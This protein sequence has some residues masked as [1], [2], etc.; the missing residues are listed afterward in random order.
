MDDQIVLDAPGQPVMEERKRKASIDLAPSSPRPRL[1]KS[2]D[3]SSADTD[4]DAQTC[5]TATPPLAPRVPRD[6]NAWHNTQAGMAH[7]AG[8]RRF[9]AFID[10]L[11]GERGDDSSATGTSDSNS[12]AAAASTAQTTPEAATPATPPATKYAD[13]FSDS[14]C[15][16]PDAANWSEAE[17]SA[18]DEDDGEDTTFW[19][20]EISRLQTRLQAA[21][22]ETRTLEEQNAEL[23]ARA[24]QAERRTE[25]AE[26]KA[27]ELGRRCDELR[28]EIYDQKTK[29]EALA[30]EFGEER[31]ARAS[32]VQFAPTTHVRLFN[33][34]EETWRWRKRMEGA[35]RADPLHTKDG[36]T[37]PAL[38]SLAT[39]Y[40]SRPAVAP[41]HHRKPLQG[42]LH[43]P[44]PS[45]NNLRRPHI[46][47]TEMEYL[48]FFKRR[49]VM[50]D[51][52]EHKRKAPR[53]RYWQSDLTNGSR[54]ER[55]SE[56]SDPHCPNL[57]R[58]VYSQ[59]DPSSPGTLRGPV[60]QDQTAAA[61]M[62]SLQ[63]VIEALRTQLRA[64]DVHARTYRE[65]NVTLAR[66]ALR[67]ERRIVEVEREATSATKRAEEAE[68]ELDRQRKLVAD[69]TKRAEE[70]D[71]AAQEA[72]AKAERA[73]ADADKRALTAETD[74][75]ARVQA[76][77][78]A[79]LRAVAEAD[80]KTTE[81]ENRVARAEAAKTEAERRATEAECRAAEAEERAEKAEKLVDAYKLVL[82]DRERI[83]P[84]QRK[85]QAPAGEAPQPDARDHPANA[86]EVKPVIE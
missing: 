40:S 70:A 28:V 5:P 71:K 15:D 58:N 84:Q 80:N 4:T 85:T 3:T 73:V 9:M 46:S 43:R 36:H 11:K 59:P 39:L 68:Q 25:L 38:S 44:R 10:D 18:S 6:A 42:S 27:R 53:L 32:R 45:Q 62:T 33:R 78:A 21:E 63:S 19:Q 30:A 49:T 66:R 50:E 64:S 81:A 14:E 41:Q 74:A 65:A 26:E 37:V 86:N 22:A 60:A 61:D 54:A 79:L 20:S 75:A 51:D 67:A 24:Q 7:V 16:S 2:T 82:D 56:L 52:D 55:Q 34:Y 69:W 57:L 23:T 13:T 29:V 1:P 47:S 35:G 48:K 76:A 83:P 12:A 77:N 72:R 17:F 8:Y 31:S